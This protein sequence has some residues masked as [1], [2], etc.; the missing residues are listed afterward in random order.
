MNNLEEIIFSIIVYGGNARAKSYDALSAAQSGDFDVAK[1]FL[2]E[3]EKELG[4][5][6]RIQT[7]I[8]QKE[9]AGEKIDIS[10]LF[11]H[12]QDHLMTAMAE[13]NLI[14]NMIELYKRIG[15]LEKKGEK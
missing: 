8:I 6:H 3:A 4:N 5:A 10:V 2:A 12:A 7:D 13:K 9:A 15:S 11:V 14:E 1:K